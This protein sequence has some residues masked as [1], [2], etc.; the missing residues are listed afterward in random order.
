[1]DRVG[2]FKITGLKSPDKSRITYGGTD[3]DLQGNLQKDHRLV[4]PELLKSKRTAKKVDMTKIM[5][6]IQQQKR[7]C[8]V[9]VPESPMPSPEKLRDCIRDLAV[10]QRNNLSSLHMNV[11]DNAMDMLLLL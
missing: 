5:A 7:T 10:V 6:K 2:D 1:M 8:S 11:S 9:V 3:Q 4:D